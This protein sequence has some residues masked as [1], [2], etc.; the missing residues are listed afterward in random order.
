M[1]ADRV[2]E[3]RLQTLTAE[4]DKIQMK[5]TDTIDDFVG[6]LSEISTKFAALG[7]K[8]EEIKLV[9]KFL[10]CLPRKRFIH[11]V[12]SLE[13]VLDLKKTSF[14]DIVGRLKV[15]EERVYDG[16]E[17]QSNDQSKLLYT[18]FESQS[19]Q[20]NYGGSRGRGGRYSTGRGRGRAGF[21]QNSGFR[22]ERDK[23]KVICYRCDKV[24]HFASVCLDRLL[25]LQEA[26]EHKD[27]E[28]H[29]AEEL[30]VHEVVY[31]NE[32]NVKPSNFE[33]HDAEGNIW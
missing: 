32:K 28:T 23:S 21:Q 19:Y 11:I 2:K 25:K 29:E 33:T 20:G 31:L 30:M 4:F 9:K 14:E 8:I 26:Q 17:D 24:G 12:A 15:Y 7:E 3:A 10:K 27:D 22:Q 16:E 18:N 13:Q 5:E 1:G 6:K